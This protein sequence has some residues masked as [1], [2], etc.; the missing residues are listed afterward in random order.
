MRTQRRGSHDLRALRSELRSRG[1][2]ARRAT[3]MP[4]PALQAQLAVTRRVDGESRSVRGN[5][6]GA[7]AI[8]VVGAFWCGGDAACDPGPRTE[9]GGL[10]T[11]GLRNSR[12]T[13]QGA[14]TAARLAAVR[15]WLTGRGGDL[16]TWQ[17]ATGGVRKTR[18]GDRARVLRWAREQGESGDQRP[19]SATEIGRSPDRESRRM[20]AALSHCRPDPGRHTATVHSGQPG[21]AAFDALDEISNDKK[22]IF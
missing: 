10:R 8:V 1:L 16:R 19:R 15:A 13:V 11:S 22:L 21:R 6:R 18:T 5:C 12:R 4:R 9:R 2:R 3:A 7:T 20:F 14:V 17:H